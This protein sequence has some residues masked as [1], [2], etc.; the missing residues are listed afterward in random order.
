MGLYQ[1][2]RRA[3]VTVA[4]IS[5]VAIAGVLVFPMYSIFAGDDNSERILVQWPTQGRSDTIEHT[6]LAQ[7]DD[8]DVESYELYWSVD[9]GSRVAMSDRLDG[10]KQTW[11]NFQRWDWNDDGPYK[12]RFIAVGDDGKEIGRTGLSLY[13]VRVNRIKSNMVTDAEVSSTEL[14]NIDQSEQIEPDTAGGTVESTHDDELTDESADKEETDEAGDSVD[15]EKEADTEQTEEESGGSEP[16]EETSLGDPSSF[17]VSADTTDGSAG[18]SLD[19]SLKVTGPDEPVDDAIVD[20][21]I[22]DNDGKQVFQEYET[23]QSFSSGQSREYT[24]TWK[25]AEA[26]EYSV[27]AGIFSSSWSTLYEWYDSLALIKVAMSSSSSSEEPEEGSEESDPESEGGTSESEEEPSG[28]E[29][30][31]GQ[32]SDFYNEEGPADRQY[33]EWIDDRPDDAELIKKIADQPIA[34]W[35]GG[36]N[37]NIKSDVNAYVSSAHR[38]GTIPVMVAYNIPDRDCGSHSAG[39]LGSLGEYEQWISDFADGVGGRDAIIVLEPDAVTLTDCLDDVERNN[40]LQV[41]GDAAALLEASGAKVYI[42]VGHAN[43]LSAHEVADRLKSAGVE[44]ASGFALN[45][46]NF[47][48]TE[49]NLRYG[50][51]ISGLIGGAHFVIDTSRN[52]NGAT[53]DNEWCNPDGRALGERPRLVGNEMP[54]LDAFIWAKVPG[55]SDGKCNGGPAAG[56]WWPEYA[57]G[58]AER[59][60]W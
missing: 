39:G 56:V 38:D 18:T 29:E 25:P 45:T 51:D 3:G 12:L 16:S 52:G 43:W 21:E 11:I 2:S 22:Y 44:K 28:G 15:E 9:G 7:V 1:F 40:R 32:S 59:A 46:S 60:A 13:R 53:S 49:K 24:F 35:F 30:S 6:F 14:K 20:L 48:S 36:W 33:D 54:L 19:V 4:V 41:L 5:V 47:V 55:E 50:R 42:D 37:S 31:S 26:G 23:G 10:Y 34:K 27:S 58:L 17:K 8:M 57:L